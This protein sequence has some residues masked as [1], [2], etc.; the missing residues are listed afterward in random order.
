[1]SKFAPSV[2]SVSPAARAA[3]PSVPSGPARSHEGEGEAALGGDAPPNDAW[4][5]C[6]VEQ[7]ESPLTQYVTRLLRGDVER[8]RDVVQDAFLKLWTQDRA[9]IDGHLGQWLYR[10][11]RNRALDVR[12]KEH[13]MTALSDEHLE[14]ARFSA[15]AHPAQQQPPGADAR[16]PQETAGAAVLALLDTLNDTQQEVLRLKF[17]GGLSYKEIAGVMDLTANHVGVLIHHAIKA[18]RERLP[19]AGPSIESG[20]LPG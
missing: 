10:V 12:R 4:I 9:T 3:S 14:A 7:F 20:R 1:V 18:L 15:I 6:A 11:C 16:L 19:A 17:Q 5:G 8:A 2:R 13:R